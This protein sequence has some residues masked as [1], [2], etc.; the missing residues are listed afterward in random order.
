MVVTGPE[1][2]RWDPVSVSSHCACIEILS[3]KAKQGDGLSQ[4]HPKV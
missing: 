3:P 2:Q 4:V 1:T